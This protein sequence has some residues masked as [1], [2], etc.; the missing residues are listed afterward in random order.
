MLDIKPFMA[1]LILFVL[2]F[3]SGTFMILLNRVEDTAEES[4]DAQ[5]GS[6][7][8]LYSRGLLSMYYLVMGDYGEV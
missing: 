4:G 6:M 2:T 3:H 5:D 7:D 8:Y 1:V